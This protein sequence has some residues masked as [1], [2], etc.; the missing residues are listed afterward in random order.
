[1]V[2]SNISKFDN[3]HHDHT[4][5]IMTLNQLI[6]LNDDELCM[7]EDPQLIKKLLNIAYTRL[8]RLA[9]KDVL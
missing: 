6:H 7:L 1:M 2:T 8:G 4:Y 5:L 9:L 3:F